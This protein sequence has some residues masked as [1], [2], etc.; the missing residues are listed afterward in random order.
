M[1]LITYILLFSRGGVGAGGRGHLVKVFD[2]TCR[3]YGLG[4]TGI[5]EGPM[6]ISV[7]SFW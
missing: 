2:G 5:F 6:P 3:C 7:V 1:F 4:F